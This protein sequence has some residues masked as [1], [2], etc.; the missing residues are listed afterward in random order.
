[1]RTDA[2][3]RYRAYGHWTG[4]PS[5][6][7]TVHVQVK[8][9]AADDLEYF[10]EDG[11][12]VQLRHRRREVIMHGVSSLRCDR[13]L[14]PRGWWMRCESLEVVTGDFEQERAT[15]I[16]WPSSDREPSSIYPEVRFRTLGRGCIE[17]YVTDDNP[18]SNTTGIIANVAR[19]RCE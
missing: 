1:M 7:D 5:W 13:A 6:P 14:P 15:V 4:P 16:R 8:G 19:L 17:W 12:A 9:D 11:N 3:V 2:H 10:D 18:W